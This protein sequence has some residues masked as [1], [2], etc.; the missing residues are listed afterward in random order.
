MKKL[1]LIIDER[2][3]HDRKNVFFRNMTILK[4]KYSIEILPSGL[5]EDTFISFLEK[6]SCEVVM[7][8]WHLYF[9]WKKAA[10][11][12]VSNVVGYFADP[13]LHFEFQSI[14][15]YQN[16]ILLDFY[17]FNLDEIEILIKLL[18]AK[19]EDTELLETF[20]KTAHYF[21]H[22]WYQADESSSQC[23]DLIFDNPILNSSMFHDRLPNLR[24]Y[25]TA[26]WLACFKEKMIQPAEQ[27][28]AK[29]V[30]AEYNKRLMIQLTYNSPSLTSKESIKELWPTADHNN[31]LFRELALQSDFLKIYH[32]PKTRGVSITGLFLPNQATASHTGEVRGFWIEN[33]L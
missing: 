23:V 33:R 25:V 19:S 27:A 6:G 15:N 26:L 20:G 3:S 10:N 1:G 16:F 28:V 32:F 31:V 17:R 29:F 18:T 11:I 12:N 30:L 2:L 14:P 24:L 22:D 21:T 13:L 8:P 5:T 7:I 9:S 4:A